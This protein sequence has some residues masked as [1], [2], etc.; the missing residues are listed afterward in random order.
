M[1]KV[2]EVRSYRCIFMK[3]DLN[4]NYTGLP[5]NSSNFQICSFLLCDFLN[6]WSFSSSPDI[7][8]YDQC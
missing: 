1:N 2:L 7:L 3:T 4:P 5:F 8:K 6:M